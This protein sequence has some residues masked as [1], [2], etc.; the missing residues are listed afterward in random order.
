MFQLPILQQPWTAQESSSERCFVHLTC[1]V[2]PLESSVCVL[3]G[4]RSWLS[5]SQ[6]ILGAG[7][8][9]AWHS[10]NVVLFTNTTTSS[11]TSLSAPRIEGGTAY[12]SKQ[13]TSNTPDSLNDKYMPIHTSTHCSLYD[14]SQQC[15]LNWHDGVTRLSSVSV[16][17]NQTW[18]VLCFQ[19]WI[20][21]SVLEN[22]NK[23]LIDRCTL[24][25]Y[26]SKVGSQGNL[27]SN[28]PQMS[29]ARFFACTYITL[30]HHIELSLLQPHWQPHMCTSQNPQPELGESEA[31]SHLQEGQKKI[32]YKHTLTSVHH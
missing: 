32:L 9:S 10:S 8:P 14:H 11:G 1:S 15:L 4:R 12:T 29:A 13:T 30:W 18:V 6:L 25:I 28:Q 23:V 17:R 16:Q 7:L 26:T 27:Y 31:L 2:L 20:S 3:S 19:K 5:L 24:T 22:R 21:S